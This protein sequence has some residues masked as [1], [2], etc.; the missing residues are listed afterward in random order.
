MLIIVLIVVVVVIAGV[1]YFVYQQSYQPNIQ[2][3]N[4]QFAGVQ[5][6]PLTVTAQNQGLI[7]RSGSF[8]YTASVNGVVYLVFDNSFSFFTA[9][10]VSV[11]YSAA[12]ASDSKSFSVNAGTKNVVQV[13]L[14]NGQSITGT[15][16]I[17]G[18]NS[19]IDFSIQQYSC[20]QTVT[21]SL[22]LVNSGNNNGYATVVLQTEAGIQAYTNKY[23]VSMGHQLPI[24]G[25]ATI[26][27]CATHNL[28]PVVTSTKG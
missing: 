14:N 16:T 25:T 26:P 1:G 27:D 6:Y 23:F 13:P 20:S 9:K 11:S 15:F 17:T 3:T 19:D 22:V 18:G 7:S 12:G 4:L 8:S 5:T 10:Q 21:F 24:Q 28:T 2:A